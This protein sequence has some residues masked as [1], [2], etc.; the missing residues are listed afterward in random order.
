MEVVPYNK[1]TELVR[2]IE[3]EAVLENHF[4]LLETY[5]WFDLSVVEKIKNINPDKLLSL[6]N[7]TAPENKYLRSNLCFNLLQVVAKNFREFDTIK[8]IETGKIWNKLS[9][10]D[11]VEKLVA[12]AMVYQKETKNWKD[13][14]I[15]ILKNLVKNVLDSYQLK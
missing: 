5:P 11:F 13:N 7:P 8:I 4:D 6:Q 15:F 12:G 1:K 3:Q 14:N 2:I 10:N 9:D